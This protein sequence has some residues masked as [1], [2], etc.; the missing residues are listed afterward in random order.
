MTIA[1]PEP[2]RLHALADY[3][4]MGT[5]SEK[6]FDDLARIAALLCGVPTALVTLVDDRRQ[7]FKARAGFDGGCE[8]PLDVGFCPLVVKAEAP[9]IIH[10]TREEGHADNAAV[11][12]GGVRFYAG[13]P[14]RT[15]AGAVLGTLCVLDRQPRPEG[16]TPGQFEGLERLAEQV[17]DQLEL[18]R[19]LSERE[20]LLAE[21]RVATQQRR[22][23]SQTQDAIAASGGDL[24][25]ILDALIEG[26][27]R[28]V[29]AAEGGV[30]ELL[31]GEELEYR[32]VGGTLTQHRGVRVPLDGSTSGTC[33]R[34]NKPILLA[35]ALLDP[36]VKADLRALIDLRSAVHAPVN[37][38]GKV[39][40]V[41]KLQSSKPDVFTERDLEL[42][43]SFAGLATVGLTEASEIAAQRAVR[44]SEARY[45]AVFESAIDYA[46]IVLDLKGNVIDWNAG[47]TRILGWAPSDVCGKPA[48]VFFTPEDREAGIPDQE[49]HSALTVGRGIDE[50]WHLRKSGER[51]WANGEMMALRNEAG[52][53]IGFVKILRDRTEQRRNAD[54]LRDTAVRLQRAQ[55][56]GGVG[57]FSIGIADAILRPSPEFCRLYGLPEREAYLS[58]AF[59]ELIVP[60]DQHLISTARSRSSGAAP[61]DVEY[62]IRRPDT[63]EVRWIARKGE[64]EH[65]DAGGPA[66]FSGVARDITA[67]RAAQEE[68]RISQERLSLAFEAAGAIG[69]W[70]WDVPN[71]RIVANARFAELYSVDPAAAAVGTSIAGY[72]DGIHPDDRA[73][74]GAKIEQ[75]LANAGEFA[76]EYRLL[77]ADGSVRWVYA[78]GRCYHDAA[79]RPLR[80][81]GVSIDITARKLDA[82]RQAAL[83]ALGDRLKD[84]SERSEIIGA[85]AEIMG[86]TLDL[87]HAGYGAVDQRRETI[88]ITRGWSMPGVAAITGL[89]RFRDYGS[90]IDDLQAGAT[91]LIADLARDARTAAAADTF[92]A[93]EARALVNL[94][95]MERG[96]FVALF[97]ALKATPH[98]WSADEVAF[99]HSVADRARAAIARV[100]AEDRQRLLNQELSHRMK[101]VLAMVQAIATQTMRTATDMDTAKEVLAGRLVA[102][103]KSHDLLLGGEI[104]STALDTLITNALELHRDRPDRFVIAGPPV[105]VGARA[106]LSLSLILHEL[107]TNAA[108]YGALST[109][110]GQVTIDWQIRSEMHEP[111]MVLSWREVGGP[112]VVAPT[113]TGFGTRLIG[114]G[115]AGSFGGVVDL[116]YPPTGVACTI[117]APLS[118]LQA[119]DLGSLV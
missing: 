78:R 109:D 91:V 108:K 6:G 4:V 31:D 87:S 15:A 92:A 55:E 80:Y 47:A 20:R 7:F 10:D 22:T 54:A 53:A 101:N 62:R 50:R 88:V 23:Y 86:Q 43:R 2:D 11:A 84:L 38:G 64:I 98:V 5:P 77:R 67:Q 13:M 33:A 21:Q 79:G 61:R 1:P 60:E 72:I 118:G 24:D 34:A 56:A 103:G 85:A 58:T 19:A 14:L 51:F 105:A 29:P 40:G 45:R 74:V 65:D 27:M 26:A 82:L 89:H 17:V 37:R 25:T 107:A 12:E 68:L 3:A 81:P 97:F 76:E 73:W 8:A 57:V 36:R 111:E 63:G 66:R 113:R 44:A 32:T 112:V 100:E 46:I 96:R 75:A 48:D 106:A 16:L 83:V 90:Y 71:D 41:L 49:M 102:L 119:H 94:P 30:L 116:A 114:R 42:V 28:A 115:L 70:D 9:L 95:V 99:L 104:G 35:D 69:W 39:L 18:R 117:T 110:A 59:E 52:A 93:M